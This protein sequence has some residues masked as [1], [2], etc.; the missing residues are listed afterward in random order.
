MAD[1]QASNLSCPLC[2]FEFSL[3]EALCEHGCPLASMCNLAR[4]PS[5]AYE[6]PQPARSVSWLKRL[7]GGRDGGGLAAHRLQ[8]LR[9]MSPGEVAEVV[10]VAREGAGRTTLAT[11]GLVPGASVTVVQQRPS[12]VVRVGETELALDPEIADRIVLRPAPANAA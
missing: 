1:P 5:C 7:F 9:R 8:T 4:C 11:F 3:E 10:S 12:C 6:F 2:G